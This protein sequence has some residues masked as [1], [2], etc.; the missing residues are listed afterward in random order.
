MKINKLTT[1]FFCMLLLVLSHISYAYTIE[2]FKKTI[3]IVKPIFNGKAMGG[4]NGFI[5]RRRQNTE[6]RLFLITAKHGI[7]KELGDPD[8]FQIYI[9][10]QKVTIPYV[11]NNVKEIEGVLL[12]ETY[13]RM[14][15][16][17]G[18]EITQEKKLQSLKDKFINYDVLLQGEES[19]LIDYDKKMVIIGYPGGQVNKD[20]IPRFC[21]ILEGKLG[22]DIIIK[23][24]DLAF[25]DM[26]ER[27]FRGFHVDINGA[28]GDCGSLLLYNTSDSNY[29][30][31]GLFIPGCQP[32]ILEKYK[33][34]SEVFDMFKSHLGNTHDSTVISK[35]IEEFYKTKDH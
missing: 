5:I 23:N 32:A 4:L 20:I 25:K 1:I 3:V 10:N 16:M 7:H 24:K 35:T 27:F 28:F 31:L 9:D 34:W 26:H 12:K 14:N 17:C 15:D 22:E 29:K 13:L 18:I 19:N 8:G 11:S 21:K 6:E 2:D 30:I 33:N